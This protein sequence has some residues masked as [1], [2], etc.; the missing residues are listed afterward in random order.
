MTGV[1]KGGAL[2]GVW[3]TCFLCEH[4]GGLPGRHMCVSGHLVGGLEGWD[5]VLVLSEAAAHAGNASS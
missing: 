3:G 1:G 5:S 4:P 2:Q